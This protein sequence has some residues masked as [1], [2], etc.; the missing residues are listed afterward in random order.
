M[1]ID[2]E[3]AVLG[4]VNRSLVGRY[5]SVAAAALSSIIVFAVLT[6]VDVAKRLGVP[7][8]VPPIVL[9][10]LSAGSIFAALYWLFSRYLW[11]WV[12]VA[13]L[14]KVPNLLGTWSCAGQTLNP[15]GSLSF[16]WQG[17]VTI[18]QNWDK[19]RIRLVTD[20][21]GSNSVTAALLWDE[22]E[23]YRLLYNYRNDPRADHPELASHLGSADLLF[24]K[25]LK[26][27]EGGYF[28]GH[29]RYTFGTMKLVRK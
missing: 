7:I 5:L 28:N 12:P 22:I 27:A 4:G 19:I 25:D 24:S 29:G 13:S 2:H 23:G 26:T 3:Y 18:S 6:A 16:G 20:K 21:S 14:L 11:K 1:A 9:S 8:N 15:D 17:T 10:F